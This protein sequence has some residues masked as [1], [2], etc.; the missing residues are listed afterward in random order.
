MGFAAL[1]NDT[2]GFIAN[3]NSDFLKITLALRPTHGLFNI[4][5]P[6][7]SINTAET[8]LAVSSSL[9]MYHPACSM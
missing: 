7:F 2:S 6:F 1:E 9:A 3:G 4:F 8:N 5:F